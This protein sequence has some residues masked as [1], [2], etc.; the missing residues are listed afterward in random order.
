M[1]QNDENGEQ[2]HG[3]TKSSWVLVLHYEETCDNWTRRMRVCW[4]ASGIRMN[5]RWGLADWLYR[6]RLEEKEVKLWTLTFEVYD[7]AARNVVWQ[8]GER[9]QRREA[10]KICSWSS[11]VFRIGESLVLVT[12]WKRP[13]IERSQRETETR[14]IQKYG[15]LILHRALRLQSEGCLF[16]SSFKKKCKLHFFQQI[17]FLLLVNR[18]IIS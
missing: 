8:L 3:V 16:F 14:I 18:K 10:L 6:R 17:P 7:A 4:L 15:R 12:V 9:M 1:R 5:T 2:I 11:L 13:K